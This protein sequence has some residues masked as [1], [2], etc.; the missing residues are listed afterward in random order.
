V[1]S[2]SFE[3]LRALLLPQEKRLPFVETGRTRHHKAVT[4]VESAGRWSLLRNPSAALRAEDSTSRPGGQTP[5]R[6]A[7]IELF[8][9]TLLRRYGVVF[10]RLL[11][12]E[13]FKVSWYELGRVYR[14]LEARG[15]IRGGYFVSGVS[16]EQFALREAIG[17][18]RSLRKRAATG[19]LL[20]ISA[21][22]PLNLLGILSPGS[23]TAA[24]I[25]NRILLRDGVPIAVLESG[26]LLSIESPTAPLSPEIERALR[27]GNLQASLRPYYS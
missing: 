13:S 5:E 20:A 7:A 27:V 2:D 22:D 10:R 6:E 19:E 17:M 26:Q 12:R 23:R 25:A 9:R 16:G 24:V 3:G 1:T 21:A 14:R 4:N 8:A 15:E 18:L 11:E